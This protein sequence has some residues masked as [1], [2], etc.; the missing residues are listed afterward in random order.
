[1]RASAAASS[2]ASVDPPAG[3]RNAPI[4][5]GALNA[6]LPVAGGIQRFSVAVLREMMSREPALLAYA[7]SDALSAELGRRGRRVWPRTL[8]HSSSAGNLLRLAWHLTVLP[9]RLRA[10]KA[11]VYYSTVPDGMLVPACPQVVTVH[12][13]IPLRFPAS[14]PRLKH[15]FRHVL[16]RIIG[17]SEAVIAMSEATRRDLR[18]EYGVD[19]ARVHV[20]HQGYREDT[21]TPADEGAVSRVR[22]SLGVERYLLAVGE[23]R[24]YKNIPRLL[25]AWARLR[26]SGVTLVLAGRASPREVDLPALAATLGVRESVRFLGYVPD[27]RLAELY[28]G[29]EAF[30]F[31]S[32]YE[33]FGIPPLEAMACGCP[34][35]ASDRASIPEVCGEA[36][37]YVDPESVESLIEGIRR[38][39]GDEA[40]R[41]SLRAAGIE[42]AAGFS[43]ANAAERILAVLRPIAAG[44]GAA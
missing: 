23:G 33:G 27:E 29:A 18:D 6:D 35:V 8:S 36:A 11:A 17:A 24:P 12:D 2:A 25:E 16:P 44:A 21:F 5:V 30:V 14:S 31:P 39:L 13:L 40:L 34:V 4:A 42:R 9:A 37:V 20:V 26:P 19:P 7:A 3:V 43:Y 15:Y 22:E 28:R 10:E 38:V 32:L 1:M 41:A